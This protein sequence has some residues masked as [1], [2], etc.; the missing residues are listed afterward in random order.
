MPYQ[1]TKNPDGDISFGSVNGELVTL[2]PSPSDYVPGGYPIVDQVQ[3]LNN[4]SLNA[5]C[6]LY[7]ILT[8][9]PAGGQAGYSP[10]WNPVTKRLQ[11]WNSPSTSDQSSIEVPINTNLAAFSFQLLLMGL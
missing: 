3:V 8:V 4:S 10:V 5:N 6:D 11:M 9:L 1:I 2:Q 7:R